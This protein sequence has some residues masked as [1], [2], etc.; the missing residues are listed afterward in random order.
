MEP[1]SRLPEDGRVQCHA[2][3]F[4]LTCAL[5]A[6]DLQSEGQRPV[7][8]AAPPTNTALLSMAIWRVQWCASGTH[9]NSEGWVLTEEEAGQPIQLFRR[10]P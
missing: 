10:E 3:H 9:S 6:T 5:S 4:S 1:E 2:F 7:D 8:T